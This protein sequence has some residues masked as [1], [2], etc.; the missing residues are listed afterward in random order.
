MS[1]QDYANLGHKV[2]WLANKGIGCWLHCHNGEYVASA[3]FN[4]T[5]SGVGATELLAVTA[6]ME[7]L[8][9]GGFI[10]G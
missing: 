6:L 2:A 3:M 9:A 8:K 7:N 4:K 5:R 10:D 1:E